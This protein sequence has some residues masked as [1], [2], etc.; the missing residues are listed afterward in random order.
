MEQR[1]DQDGGR[2]AAIHSGLASALGFHPSSYIASKSIV[3]QAPFRVKRKESILENKSGKSQG[4]WG[5]ASPIKRK[6]FSFWGCAGTDPPAS[7]SRVPG[8][9]VRSCKNGSSSP[10]PRTDLGRWRSRRGR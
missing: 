6:T 10:A 8:G 5:T 9:A 3:R 4:V 2:K 7:D 1:A